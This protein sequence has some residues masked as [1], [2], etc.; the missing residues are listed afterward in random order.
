MKYKVGDKIRNVNDHDDTAT[1]ISKSTLDNEY[2]LELKDG[3]KTRM[4][5]D[6]I[7]KGSELC[8]GVVKEEFKIGDKVKVLCQGTSYNNIGD[9]GE[10]TEVTVEFNCTWFRVQVDGGMTTSNYHLADQI[11]LI[12]NGGVTHHDKLRGQCTANHIP[13]TL[14][15]HCTNPTIKQVLVGVVTTDKYDFCT[16]CRKEKL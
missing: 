6:H 11:E 10:I 15:C 1:I 5:S 14:Y 9:I 3:S 2:G 12:Q 8:G 7:D 4:N 16:S 13:D